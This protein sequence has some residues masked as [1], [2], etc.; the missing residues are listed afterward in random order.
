MNC[1][2]ED[3]KAQCEKHG[4]VAKDFGNGHWQIA[5]GTMRVNWYPLSRKRSIYIN[6]S[7]G[8]ATREMGTAED[9][10]AFALGKKLFEVAKH[11]RTK[12]KKTYRNQKE[13]LLRRNPHCKWCRAKLTKETATIVHIVPLAMGEFDEPANWA[14]ACEPCNKGRHQSL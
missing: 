7:K 11:E 5:N 1:C 14:L 13:R 12:R 9:A 3:F 2:F 6:L 8:A 4:L 10:I